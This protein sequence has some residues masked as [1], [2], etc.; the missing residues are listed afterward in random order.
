MKTELCIIQVIRTPV[1]NS[2]INFDITKKPSDLL[3]NVKLGIDSATF[4]STDF[5]RRHLENI[6]TA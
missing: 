6:Q 4:F 5:R 3:A 1:L 2:I